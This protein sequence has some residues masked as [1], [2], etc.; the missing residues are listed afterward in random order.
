MVFSKVENILSVA[1]HQKLKLVTKVGYLQQLTALDS[2]TLTTRIL[3][4]KILFSVIEGPDYDFKFHSFNKNEIYRPISF[5][6]KLSS[7]YGLLSKR[8]FDLVDLYLEVYFDSN[9]QK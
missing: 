7:D 1:K 3:P 9:E 2:W 4:N 8:K 6:I 5:I